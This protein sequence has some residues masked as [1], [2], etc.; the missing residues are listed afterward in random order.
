VIQLPATVSGALCRVS[1]VNQ[2]HKADL[3]CLNFID[4]SD[5]SVATLLGNGDGT[6]QPAVYSGL[7]QGNGE[8]DPWIS[9]PADL[10]GDGFPDLLINDHADE[11]TFVLLGD[12]PES[13][14]MR[15]LCLTQARKAWW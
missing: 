13:S 4:A 2:D 5:V 14:R 6:F 3:V 11:R 1:D 7:V 10:N 12:G 9:E 8:L 15:R